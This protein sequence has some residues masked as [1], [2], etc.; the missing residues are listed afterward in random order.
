[1]RDK[2]G[3]LSVSEGPSGLMDP[4]LRGKTGFFSIPTSCSPYL[5]RSCPQLLIFVSWNLRLK[6][7]EKEGLIPGFWGIIPGFVSR[8]MRNASPFKGATVGEIRSS[9]ARKDAPVLK[10]D[11]GSTGNDGM[12]RFC[13]RNPSDRIFFKIIN[14]GNICCAKFLKKFF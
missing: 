4:E 11:Q 3:L 6:N 2:T 7:S 10:T 1:M 13:Q 12:G 5:K 8:T 9:G 14:S